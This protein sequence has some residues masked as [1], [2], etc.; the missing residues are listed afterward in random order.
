[1]V[2]RVSADLSLQRPNSSNQR[3]L[4]DVTGLAPVHATVHIHACVMCVV[5]HC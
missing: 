2:E 3:L 1:M 4:K 5:S